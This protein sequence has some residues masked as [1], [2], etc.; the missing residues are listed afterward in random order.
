MLPRISVV[1]PS[2]NQAEYLE[3][4]ILSVLGQGY[5]NLEYIVMDGGS[6]DDSAAIIQRYESHLAFWVS[7]KDN[8]QAAAINRGFGQATGDII[9]WLNSDDF[10]LPGILHRVAK[11]LTSGPDLIYGDCISFS[12]KGA[13]SVINRPPAYDRELLGMWDYIVQPS[14]FWT[15]SLWEKAG[16]LNEG[17]HYAFDWEWFLRASQNGRF[18]KCDTIF[19]A[20]RFHESHKS[21]SGGDKRGREICD[22]AKKYGGA[23]ADAHYQ[24]VISHLKAL[25]NY[26]HM[27]R[28][29]HG[30]GIRSDAT[31]ARALNPSLWNLPA[32]VT[33]DG[34]RKCL[35]MLGV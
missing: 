26:E 21:S 4:T 27:R 19:S 18:Q 3:Q 10:F 29:I 13:R 17:L 9:C 35:S 23:T 28:R 2:Y 34:V 14:S 20:Y 22:V 15:R 30:R 12:Q 7:E 6:S 5:P 33:W 16:V 11:E 1:T 24:F 32:N 31:L 25:Q 8:G